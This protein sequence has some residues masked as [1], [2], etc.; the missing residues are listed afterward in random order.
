MACIDAAAPW[1][2][3]AHPSHPQTRSD[4]R[5]GHHD[6]RGKLR[7]RHGGG[8]P[9]ETGAAVAKDPRAA[10]LDQLDDEEFPALTMGQAAELLGVQPAFL[11]NLDGF[12]VLHP[13]RSAGRHRRYSRAQLRLAARLRELTDQ[14]HPLAAAAQIVALQDDLAAAEQERDTAREERDQARGVLAQAHDELAQA[15]R[16]LYRLH[17]EISGRGGSSGGECRAGATT[18]DAVDRAPGR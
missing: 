5:S 8:C 2:D 10:R 14:G 9:D 11:R 3:A 17:Q 6:V 4:A 1:D 7:G 16:D 12:G 15:H 13:K 18:D